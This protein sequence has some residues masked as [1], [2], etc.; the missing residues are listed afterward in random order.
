MKI[1]ISDKAAKRIAFEYINEH[2]DDEKE[3]KLIVLAVFDNCRLTPWSWDAMLRYAVKFCSREY[4]V[5]L[6]VILRGW[7]TK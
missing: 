2:H 5:P 3:M 7:R 1:E 4:Y 6:D